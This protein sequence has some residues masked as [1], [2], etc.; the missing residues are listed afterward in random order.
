MFGPNGAPTPIA[1]A[2]DDRLKI[3]ILKLIKEAEPVHLLDAI[4]RLTI[5]VYHLSNEITL[6]RDPIAVQI[7][8]Y[9]VIPER[10]PDPEPVDPND[11]EIE[12][13]AM[14]FLE[15]VLDRQ[16]MQEGEEQEKGG[17]GEEG[18]SS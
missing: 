12:K 1:P 9:S 13:R 2:L 15:R 3:G 11:P 6:M 10:E 18:A 16:G 7:D 14:E 4:D 17:R 8:P 5:A